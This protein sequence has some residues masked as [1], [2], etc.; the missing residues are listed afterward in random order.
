MLFGGLTF[1]FFPCYEVWPHFILCEGVPV[2][3][4][5]ECQCFHD[6]PL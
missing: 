3:L 6:S 5:V 2:L 1:D 4:D